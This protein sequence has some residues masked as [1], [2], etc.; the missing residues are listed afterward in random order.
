MNINFSRL[1]KLPVLTRSGEMLGRVYNCSLS[2]DTHT[3]TEYCVRSS[4][5]SQREYIIKPSQVVE[6][7]AVKMTV[8][9]AVL[10][11]L[12]KMNIPAL[13]K[14]VGAE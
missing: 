10:K 11:D 1:K 2:V 14:M 6:I 13:G 12:L 4:R 3:V 9:D 8:D 5:F 7:T